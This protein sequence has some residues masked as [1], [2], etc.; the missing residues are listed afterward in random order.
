M[1][2][3]LQWQATPFDLVTPK[4]TVQ[5]CLF[6][7]SLQLLPCLIATHFILFSLVL[8]FYYICFLTAHSPIW[9]KFFCRSLVCFNFCAL[10]SL[11]LPHWAWYCPV[12]LQDLWQ[13]QDKAWKRWLAAPSQWL[14]RI[15]QCLLLIIDTSFIH[16]LDTCVLW[17]SLHCLLVSRNFLHL[18]T[19]DSQG[20]TEVMWEYVAQLSPSDMPGTWKVQVA[21]EDASQAAS[22]CSQ[23]MYC[24]ADPHLSHDTIHV[25]FGLIMNECPQQSEQSTF[26][27]FLEKSMSTTSVNSSHGPYLLLSCTTLQLHSFLLL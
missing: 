23:R 13:K 12:R 20:P 26:E 22:H 19:L 18:Q 10:L 17:A 21:F 11:W 7:C 9:F 25:Y 27:G 1:D 4:T 6:Y 15:S 14:S 2:Y 5:S 24:A 3:Q 8:Q 16:F